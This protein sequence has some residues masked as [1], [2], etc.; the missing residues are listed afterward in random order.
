MK[1]INIIWIIFLLILVFNISKLKNSKE[2]YIN[3]LND[4]KNSSYLIK[5]ENLYVR[6]FKKMDNPF[7]K[8][9]DKI[10]KTNNFIDLYSLSYQP[11][12]L[13]IGSKLTY[14]MDASDNL[15]YM[16]NY[17][18][19]N[20]NLDC[21]KEQLYQAR[22]IAI[23]I[24]GLKTKEAN[25]KEEKEFED[26]INDLKTVSDTVKEKAKK[27][28]NANDNIE[29]VKS[30][31]IFEDNDIY[32]HRKDNYLVIGPFNYNTSNIQEE[33]NNL[34][35]LN[36]KEEEIPVVIVDENDE[37]IELEQNKDFYVLI[38]DYYDVFQIDLTITNK[39][40]SPAIY[41]KNDYLVATYIDENKNVNKKYTITKSEEDK[42][43][44]K[45]FRL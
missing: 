45:A 38:P 1:K 3:T 41:E 19:P 27:I 21:S 34:K 9:F 24:I 26:I 31:I 10:Y 29:K 32:W 2:S 17:T 13:K 7:N 40:L 33:Q 30:E 16:F 35:I 6:D 22:Q 14:K 11:I 4:Y 43:N 18:Y 28:I 39:K 12:N 23:W 36:D 44:I 25:I 5:T 42:G 37:R 15:S 8:P 20:A